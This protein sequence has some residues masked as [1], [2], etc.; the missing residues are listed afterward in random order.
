MMLPLGKCNICCSSL[1]VLADEERSETLR[2]IAE[3]AFAQHA[4]GMPAMRDQARII[5]LKC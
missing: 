1:I 2:S 3:G 4:G 5:A